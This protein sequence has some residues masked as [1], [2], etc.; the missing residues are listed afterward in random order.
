MKTFAEI[1]S[2]AKNLPPL[3]QE[4]L[5]H[6]PT[7]SLQNRRRR[8]EPARGRRMGNDYLLEAPLGAPPMTPERVKQL[9]EDSKDTTDAHLVSLAARHHLKLATLDMA[10]VSKPWAAG[11]AFNP[12]HIL[13]VLDQGSS[14]YTTTRQTQPDEGSVEKLC[15][16]IRA[17]EA[18]SPKP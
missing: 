5:L 2:S 8:C 9:L 18:A 17:Y 11:V 13:R 4:E 14:D 3:E 1:Q 7:S 15:V 10:L 6:A 12:L 16:E